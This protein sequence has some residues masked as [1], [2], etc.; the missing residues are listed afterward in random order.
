ME[1]VCTASLFLL[2]L[3]WGAPG[4]AFA[5]TASYFL[6]MFP[7]FWYAGKPIGLGVGPIFAVV[8]KF[9]AA[10]VGAAIVTALI[11]RAV[12]PFGA[13][14]GASGAFARMVSVSFIFLA[15]YFAG[16]IALYR[17]LKPINETVSLLHDLLPERIVRSAMPAVVDV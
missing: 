2:T 16:V 1:F 5:W 3:R 7:G 4:I 14:L 8:W 6:L 15:L 11:I 9:F 13:A 12:P 17:G 10:S